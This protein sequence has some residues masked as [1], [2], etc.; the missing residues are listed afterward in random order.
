MLILMNYRTENPSSILFLLQYDRIY[1]ESTL[2]VN[3]IFGSKNILNFTKKTD[4]WMW[5]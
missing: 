2:N 5:A 3:I 1:F 4:S